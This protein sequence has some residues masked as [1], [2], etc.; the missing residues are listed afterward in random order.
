M[1]DVFRFQMVHAK[2]MET[3]CRKRRIVTEVSE[4]LAA[5]A[6]VAGKLS[7]D[8]VYRLGCGLPDRPDRR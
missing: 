1:A 8:C 6:F 3:V 5:R 7:R 4:D 2:A